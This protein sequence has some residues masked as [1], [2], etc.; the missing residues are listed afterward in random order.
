MTGPKGKS[1]F[2]FSESLN[3]PCEAKGNI[4]RQDQN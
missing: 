1:E 3:V 4:V 2:C